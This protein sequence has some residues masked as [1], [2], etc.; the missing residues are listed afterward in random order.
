L[1]DL[2]RVKVDHVDGWAIT[3]RTPLRRLAR[4]YHFHHHHQKTYDGYRLEGEPGRWR[5]IP[6]PQVH[7]PPDDVEAEP[8]LESAMLELERDLSESA[9]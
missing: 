9:R 8:D 6:P 4:L 2:E 5:W 1:P 3:R 7:S